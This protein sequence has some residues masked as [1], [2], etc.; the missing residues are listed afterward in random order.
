MKTEQA[1]RRH[2]LAGIAIVLVLVVGVGGWASLTQISGAVIA[3]GI[4]VVDSHVQEVQHPTGGVV[5]EI[6]ARDGDRVKGG[7][8]LIRL[9][10]TV[11]RANLGIVTKTLDELTARRARLVAERD[12]KPAVVFPD[13]L[14]RRESDP[15]VAQLID[16][17]R[18]LFDVRRSAR[19]G[20]KQQLQ[21]RISQFR[22]EGDGYT[23][24]VSAKAQEITLID[25]ELDGARTLFQKNLI[26]ISKM[27]ELERNATQIEGERGQF[28]A[29]LA[30]ANGKIAETQLQILQVDLNFGSEVG[31]ELREI[32]AKLGELAERKIAAEDQLKRLDIRAPQDG[33]VHESTVH[34]VGGVI[35]PGKPL[36][37]I[38]PTADKLVVEAKVSP[39]DIDQLGLGQKAGLHFS[40]FNQRTT[41]EINGT[42]S[43]IA[44][45]V[46]VDQ[47]TGQGYY[48]IEIATRPE[49]IARLGQVKL[50]PGMP[51]EAFIKTHDRKVIS[52]L[53]KP[54][55]DQIARAFRE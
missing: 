29:A 13:E 48:T 49:E 27:T 43:R 23:A 28:V 3:P 38:V 12:D 55:R 4:L 34:T 30:Q 2:F 7:D 21:E 26:P 36:M 45:D 41:P 16:S 11:T 53:V 42:V 10:P 46:T 5:A 19:L 47:R 24:Q 32:E 6:L 25:R 31:A 22:K 33:F 51:V 40:A 17:E 9:D 54:L 37:L 18:R 8:V 35:S 15:D 20:Q 39:T 44:A 1:I 52:Y 14:L 50:V